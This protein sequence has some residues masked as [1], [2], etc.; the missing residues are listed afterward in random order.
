MEFVVRQT[1]Y[2]FCVFQL[3]K[4]GRISYLP[5]NRT[6]YNSKE[7]ANKIAEQLNHGELQWI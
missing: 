7:R 4:V 2:G 6:I 5:Y 3:I 1:R